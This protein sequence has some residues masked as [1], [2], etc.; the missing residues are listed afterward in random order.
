MEFGKIDD[1]IKSFNREDSVINDEIS[2]IG[3]IFMNLDNPAAVIKLKNSSGDEIVIVNN[4]LIFQTENVELSGYNGFVHNVNLKN[5][6]YSKNRFGENIND[7]YNDH[8][9]HGNA[10]NHMYDNFPYSEQ[11][12]ANMTNE[13]YMHQ[14]QQMYAN[15]Q[16]PHIRP[17]NMSSLDDFQFPDNYPQP[18]IHRKQSGEFPKYN[19]RKPHQLFADMDV[20]ELDKDTNGVDSET[21]NEKSSSAENNTNNM[22]GCVE[23][24]EVMKAIDP[25][26]YNKVSV[27]VRRHKRNDMLDMIVVALESSIRVLT[28]D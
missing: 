2:T 7:R 22:F 4:T 19:S 13:R 10:K 5:Y 26:L 16:P 14:Q 23:I 27:F 8:P 21:G 15:Q 17:E 3:R 9:M 24:H 1:L 12:G 25:N 20:N 6:F 11:P 28:R 18:P